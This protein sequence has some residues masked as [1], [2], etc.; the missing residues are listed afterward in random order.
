MYLIYFTALALILVL[1]WNIYIGTLHATTYLQQH[2]RKLAV[3]TSIHLLEVGTKISIYSNYL[4]TIEKLNNG[5]TIVKIVPP[6]VGN[7]TVVPP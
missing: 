7:S 5:T 6:R 3:E 1:A 2:L 4:I